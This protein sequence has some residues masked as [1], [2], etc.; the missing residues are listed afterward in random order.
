MEDKLTRLRI[1]GIIILVDISEWE[2][3]LVCVAKADG[4]V[5]LCGDYKVTVNR[6]IQ[7]KQHPIPIPK[8]MISKFLED[9]NVQ[10]YIDFKMCL[11]ATGTGIGLTKAGNNYHTQGTLSLCEAI[12]RNVL[13]SYNLAAVR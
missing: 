4:K 11:P 10:R 5:R 2:T 7:M 13:K 3:P 1:V 8:E 6:I 12:L 9:R